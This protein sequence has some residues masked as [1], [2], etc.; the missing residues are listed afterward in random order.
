LAE[1]FGSIIL[2]D[3]SK[4]KESLKA[5]PCEGFGE[6]KKNNNGK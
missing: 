2:K 5:P 6:A 4:I 3:F 1:D